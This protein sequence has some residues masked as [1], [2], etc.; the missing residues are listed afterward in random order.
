MICDRCR[1][2]L[3]ARPGYQV[4]GCGRWWVGLSCA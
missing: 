1:V 3:A 2:E 4:C